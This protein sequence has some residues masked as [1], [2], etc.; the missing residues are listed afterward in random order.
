MWDN[1]ADDAKQI[2]WVREFISA[3]QPFSYGGFCPNYEADTAPGR[4]VLAFGAEK[5]ARLAAAKQ[6]YDPSNVFRL[7]QN[8]VPRGTRGDSNILR[9]ASV[10]S[11]D[12]A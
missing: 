1:P 7:N 12:H 2:G 5:Y 6:K 8:I 4:V 9:T 3:M 11:S 10:Q